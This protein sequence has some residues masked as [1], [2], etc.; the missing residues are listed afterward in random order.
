LVSL[1]E[2]MRI[3]SVLSPRSPSAHASLLRRVAAQLRN[4]C[5][6]AGLA[7]PY[8]LRESVERLLDAPP[9]G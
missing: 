7:I 8:D 9:D 4:T 2:A 1:V 5:A 3:L 6:A